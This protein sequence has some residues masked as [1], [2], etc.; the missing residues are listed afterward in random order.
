VQ[1]KPAG[2]MVN[3][4]ISFTVG[5]NEARSCFGSQTLDASRD[6]NSAVVTAS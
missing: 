6:E 1:S 4:S 2:G 3:G 5:G